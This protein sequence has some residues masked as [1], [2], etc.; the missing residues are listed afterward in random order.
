MSELWQ[1]EPKCFDWEHFDLL[2]GWSLV[3]LALIED[4]STT[5]CMWIN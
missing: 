3:R 5:H 2:D 1:F 4:P